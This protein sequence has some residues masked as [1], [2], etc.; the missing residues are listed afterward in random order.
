MEAER[1]QERGWYSN[2]GRNAGLWTNAAAWV[3]REIIRT[4]R[5]VR[6]GSQIRDLN[7]DW[8]VVPF[9]EMGDIG[10]GGDCLNYVEFALSLR[11]IQLLGQGTQGNVW[12]RD[13]TLG[14]V[15]GW[16]MRAEV[17]QLISGRELG[18]L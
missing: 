17:R 9:P 5:G 15:D 18:C 1:G 2:Q 6:C 8:V 16:I 12:S 11:D 13:R 7:A 10:S 4:C 3:H 14:F